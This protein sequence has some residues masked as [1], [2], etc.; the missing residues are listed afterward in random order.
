[1]H[2]VNHLHAHPLIRIF[3]ARVNNGHRGLEKYVYN[4]LAE[5]GVQFTGIFTRLL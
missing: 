5:F 1:M 2:F 3:N 4:T